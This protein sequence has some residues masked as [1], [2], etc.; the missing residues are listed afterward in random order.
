MKQNSI[1]AR[2]QY[3]SEGATL[4]AGPT[5]ED[6]EPES[7]WVFLTASKLFCT[8]SGFLLA[9][10][11]L[12]VAGDL[13]VAASGYAAV[14]VAIALAF[15]ALVLTVLG[16]LV[17]LLGWVALNEASTQSGPM[18]ALYF[19]SIIGLVIGVVVFLWRDVPQPGFFLLFGGWILL[20]F[21]PVVF[22]PVV[23]GHASVFLLAT[24]RLRPL[25]RFNLLLVGSATLLTLAVF[26][27]FLYASS[28][29][30]FPQWLPL[31]GLMSLG[32]GFIFLELR[33]EYD[34][35]CRHL[36]LPWISQPTGSIF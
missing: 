7:V 16:V 21:L 20:P 24:H 27:L 30:G 5:A 32:Y 26:G 12:F 15:L 35:R 4:D 36:P 17:H 22:G 8:G 19:L 11:G 28:P 18:R 25:H 1:I 13:I 14:L 31:A 33:E 9:A 2:I 29:G 6:L 3:I 34:R 10:S 23:I